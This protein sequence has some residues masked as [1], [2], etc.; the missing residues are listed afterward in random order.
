MLINLHSCMW[1]TVCREWTK[2]RKLRSES[3]QLGPMS[4]Q[5]LSLVKEQASAR[6]HTSIKLKTLD[7]SNSRWNALPTSRASLKLQG[8][9][10]ELAMLLPSCLKAM[11]HLL[12]VRLVR[13]LCR[14]WQLLQKL[15]VWARH[16]CLKHLLWSEWRE[17]RLTEALW[18]LSGM[19]GRASV[20]TYCDWENSRSF[21]DYAT[22]TK[23]CRHHG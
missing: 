15:Q 3:A 10:K 20:T 14:R 4:S 22:S 1:A 17:L 9:R 2:V 7:N 18:K 11:H 13:L 23:A 21:K 16:P 6:T 5:L 12:Q 19:G 8:L